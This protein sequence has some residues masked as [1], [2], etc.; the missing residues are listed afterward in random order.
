[1]GRYNCLYRSNFA[2][3]KTNLH[4]QFDEVE[5][6]IMQCHHM[7]EEEDHVSHGRNMN[8][9]KEHGY[10]LHDLYMIRIRFESFSIRIV[11]ESY[12][13]ELEMFRVPYTE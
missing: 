5:Y 8:G 6:A 1:M 4:Y 11:F 3:A 7:Y 9:W 12:F 10:T 13:F 2:R